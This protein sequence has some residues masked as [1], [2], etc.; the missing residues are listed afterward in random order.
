MA[1]GFDVEQWNPDESR[2][3]DDCIQPGERGCNQVKHGHHNENAPDVPDKLRVEAR[4]HQSRTIGGVCPVS[5]AN[6]AGEEE[7]RTVDGCRKRQFMILTE[8]R[9]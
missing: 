6:D 5:V 7:I 9:S 4:H 3:R 8:Q 1:G 2:D